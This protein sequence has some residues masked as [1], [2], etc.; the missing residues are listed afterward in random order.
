MLRSLD[1]DQQKI[2]DKSIRFLFVLDGAT[3]HL[4]AY[5]CKST[6]PSEVITKLHERMDTPQM[7]PKTICADMAFHH[8]HDVQAFYRMDNVKRLPPGPHTPWPNRAERCVRL[9][10]EFL[11][12]LVDTAFKIRMRTLCR[13]LLLASSCARQRR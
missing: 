7:N 10:K 13:R 8:P 12:A 4:T 6:S 3:S 1:M 11:S 2:G 9:F 5:P